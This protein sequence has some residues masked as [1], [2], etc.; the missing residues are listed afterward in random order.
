[1]ALDQK[2]LQAIKDIFFKFEAH[3]DEKLEKLETKILAEL[4][5]SQTEQTKEIA[6]VINQA[7]ETVDAAYATK[8]EVAQLRREVQQI[9]VRLAN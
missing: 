9:K 2:D 7:I 3:L 8:A 6:E 4:Y 1:M 5:R